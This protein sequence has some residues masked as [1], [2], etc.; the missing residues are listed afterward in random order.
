M[1]KSDLPNGDK[2]TSV[3]DNA[4]LFSAFFSSLFILIRS[5]DPALFDGCGTFFQCQHCAA[6][7]THSLQHGDHARSSVITSC[8]LD[9]TGLAPRDEDQET[10]EEGRYES[11][12]Q[13]GNSSPISPPWFWVM[14]RLCVTKWTKCMQMFS[15]VMSFV[16]AV[17]FASRRPG[18]IKQSQIRAYVLKVLLYTEGTEPKNLERNR[19]VEYV[20]L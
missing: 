15:S 16:P 1:L 14:Y 5:A 9:N 13:T 4:I 18:S 19:G 20:C 7:P 12:E 10:R 11:K 8:N 6:R 17:Y 3:W 2:I